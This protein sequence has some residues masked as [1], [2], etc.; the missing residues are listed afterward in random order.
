M[1]DS[2]PEGWGDK[3]LISGEDIAA[4]IAEGGEVWIDLGGR[5]GVWQVSQG[6]SYL[7]Q[8]HERF[9]AATADRNRVFW[10]VR[11]G[12]LLLVMSESVGVGVPKYDLHFGV[13]VLQA[14]KWYN[15]GQEAL[16]YRYEWFK[17][18]DGGKGLPMSLRP[19]R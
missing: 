14:M 1:K 6:I 9:A 16:D 17:K 13:S 15:D 12:E 7:W 19:L 3:D 10:S 18:Y 5:R 4:V 2:W 11:E 8:G